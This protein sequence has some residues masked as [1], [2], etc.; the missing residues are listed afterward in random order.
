MKSTKRRI[1]ALVIA[2]AALTGGF[3]AMSA[4]SAHADTC[5]A[6]VCIPANPSPAW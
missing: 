3:A 1:V 4:S 5:L 2:T 6:G